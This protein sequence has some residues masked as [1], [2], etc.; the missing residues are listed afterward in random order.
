[1]ADQP[2]GAGRAAR[3]P[4]GGIALVLP[5]RPSGLDWRIWNR[6]LSCAAQTAHERLATVIGR[7]PVVQEDAEVD[8]LRCEADVDIWVCLHP[9]LVDVR[10]A[11]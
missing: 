10:T 3:L 9:P 6:H 8:R 2:P 5:T 1:M 7:Q 4:E 11:G